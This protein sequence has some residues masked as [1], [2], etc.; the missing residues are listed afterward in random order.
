MEINSETNALL[1]SIIGGI[2]SLFSLL[3]VK[4]IRPLFKILNNHD[5]FIVSINEIKSELKTNGGKSLKDNVINLTATID[6][7]ETRQKIIEQ[8]TKAGLHYSN[9][10]LFETDIEGRLVWNNI[11][12]CSLI[13]ESKA[14]EGYDW[15]NLVCEHDREAV[16]DEF[17]SCLKTNRKFVKTT[18]TYEG[19]KIRMIGYPYKISEYKHGG[20]LVSI[21]SLNEV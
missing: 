11:H 10:P 13:R 12:F 5:G 1:I 14:L 2:F 7:I 8:R 9:I 16:F 19:K 20:F 21:T 3:W 15:I 4:V 18:E 17:M 6:R